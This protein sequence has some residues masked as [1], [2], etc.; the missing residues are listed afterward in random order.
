MQKQITQK[1]Q[2]FGDESYYLPRP[3]GLIPVLQDH[4]EP[5]LTDG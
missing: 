2:V 1:V 4:D 5:P 3:S